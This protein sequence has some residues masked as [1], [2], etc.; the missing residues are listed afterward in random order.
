MSATHLLSS[1]QCC[2]VKQRLGA[3][4][5]H[6]G[7]TQEKLMLAEASPAR[8]PKAIIDVLIVNR[9]LNYYR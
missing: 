8:A 6:V 7:L 1:P 9:D 5:S 4:M 3:L 2:P